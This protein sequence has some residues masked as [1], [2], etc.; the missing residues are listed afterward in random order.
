MR[1]RV[2]RRG[3]RGLRLTMTVQYAKV[4]TT[5]RSGVTCDRCGKTASYLDDTPEVFDAY[6]FLS[7]KDTGGYASV[8]MDGQR[9]SI[10]LC[11]PCTIEV[12]GP[13]IQK[14]KR[15]D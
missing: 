1:Q 5:T 3:R 9:W 12:L 10:D 14:E 4:E 6:D 13:W 15:S 11:G 7:F 8:H 2:V